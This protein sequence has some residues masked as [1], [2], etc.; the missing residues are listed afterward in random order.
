M[1]IQLKDAK[2]AKDANDT[3][4]SDLANSGPLGWQ[5]RCER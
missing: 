3:K 4:D 1:A 5:E 2:D